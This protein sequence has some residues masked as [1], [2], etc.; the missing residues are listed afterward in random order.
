M[1]SEAASTLQREIFLLL[2]LFTIKSAIDYSMSIL[3]NWFI[4][5]KIFKCMI[6]SKKIKLRY[7][8]NKKSA[9]ILNEDIEEE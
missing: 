3:K 5:M 6:D 2:D 4:F 1:K 9:R 8:R 7:K